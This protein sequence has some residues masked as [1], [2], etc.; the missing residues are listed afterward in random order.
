MNAMVDW[1]DA[2]GVWYVR[3]EAVLVAL[4]PVVLLF[5]VGVSAA[6]LIRERWHRRGRKMDDA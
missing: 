1:L 4:T 2:I 6:P 3:V 5:V